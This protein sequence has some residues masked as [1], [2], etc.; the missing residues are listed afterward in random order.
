M[1]QPVD[2][3]LLA[4]RDPRDPEPGADITQMPPGEFEG[5]G[6]QLSFEVADKIIVNLARTML[7]RL[8]GSKYLPM[9][10]EVIGGV[11]PV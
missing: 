3:Y 8:M 6:D 1:S 10:V 9:G 4:K 7:P 5:S 11:L 2:P